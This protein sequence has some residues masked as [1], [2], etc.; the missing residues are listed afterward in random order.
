MGS[1]VIDQEVV[2]RSFPEG[3]GKLELI[4]MYE[5]KDNKIAKAWFIFGRKTLDAAS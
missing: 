1:I 3:S 4:A 2:T 5:V